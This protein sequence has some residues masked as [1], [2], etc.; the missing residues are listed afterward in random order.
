IGTYFPT[1]SSMAATWD[2]DMV[3]TIAKSIG[4]EARGARGHL[5][6]GPAM[7]I[8]RNPKTGRS[9]EYFTED[10]YLNGRTAIA[11][12][13]GIQS[14]KIM[15][16]LKHYV[17]NNQELDR[18]DIN[19]TVSERALREI[20]FPG[21]K[22]AIQEG[23]AW[24][25][26]S[27]YNSING[28][29]G[30]ENLWLQ[31]TV[32]ME[33]W[34]FRGFVL[35]DWGGTHSTVQSIKAGLSLEMPRDKVYGEPLL[36]AVKSGQ[37]K[38][39][40]LDELVVKF[41]R[42]FLWTGALDG[43]IPVHP[44]WIKSQNHKD[45]AREAATKAMVLLKNDKNTLPFNKG[46]I[47]KLAVIGPNGDYGNHFNG[48]EYSFTLFQGNGSSKVKLEK[49]RM[50]TPYQGIKELLKNDIEVNYA[51]GCY[52]ETG[53]GP[54]PLGYIRT[55]DSTK[56]GFLVSFYDNRDFS[57]NP[58]TSIKTDM[59]YDWGSAIEIPEL[60]NDPIK[61][62]SVRFEGKLI[63]PESK[64]YTLEL[65]HRSGS[66]KLY[67]ND[68]LVDETVKASDVYF[69]TVDSLYLESGKEYNIRVDYV[70]GGRES[71]ISFYW[72]YEN[73]QYLQNALAL[74]SSSD[75]VLLTVGFSGDIGETEAGDRS[76][77]A[78][79]PAQENLINEISKVNPNCA[80]VIIAGSS[81]EMDNWI[82][83]V[84]SVLMGWLCGEQMG[85]AMYD[86]LFGD[87]N[88]SGKLPVTFPKTYNDYPEG[89]YSTTKQINYSEGI[90]VGYRYF[91]HYNKEVLFPFGHGLS[92]TTFQYNT[93]QCSVS[94]S[95]NNLKVEVI[96]SITNTGPVAGEEVVQLY[97]KDLVASVERPIQELKGFTK[98]S[99]NPGETKEVTI[100]LDPTSL[101]FFDMTSKKWKME[102][103]DFEIRVGSSSRT[104]HL[105]DVITIDEDF[106]FMNIKKEMDPNL[107]YENQGKAANLRVY[108]NP[109]IESVTF[110][111]SEFENSYDINI[112]DS[113]GRA[114]AKIQNCNTNLVHFYR[115]GLENGLY[116]YQVASGNKFSN[117]GKFI[118][119]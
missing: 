83:N 61:W 104:I 85:Y 90:Y 55:P 15:A 88:P 33:D 97:V 95:L 119:M 91:D 70:S 6:A 1:S 47:N 46:Q 2:K 118:L 82:N 92:Y 66:A 21:F 3:Y 99:L 93:I 16:N 5:N 4:H 98:V 29:F 89:F 45:I 10:P 57:G 19:V 25:V 81:V 51:P 30:N 59:I 7:N 50:I 38:E 64:M 26:M 39:A 8:V 101:A 67:I 96:I 56:N 58:S 86:V 22:A 80:V 42:A 87:V 9:F 17:C 102:A 107:V 20:Y 76:R 73:D 18:H 12:T 53:T 111:L 36:D 40:E 41:L 72:D 31:K 109:A 13:Q 105:V 34:G 32:L 74:A 35:S 77:L 106:Y 103:G 115:K 23:G 24:S 60:G 68:V 79:Y 54:I 52:A 27:S 11:Y 75:A 63:I 14:E 94:D 108:P 117:T 48:G 62:F 65:R 78:L 100:T 69:N 71:G 112:S 116:L 49:S 44:E 114:V 110:E 37:V 43:E 28:S 113:L 84:P